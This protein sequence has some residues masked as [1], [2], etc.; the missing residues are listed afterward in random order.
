MVCSSREPEFKKMDSQGAQ[1]SR[2]PVEDG[3]VYT[4]RWGTVSP[5]TVLAAVAAALEPQEVEISLLLTKPDQ[6]NDT[7]KME[8]FDRYKTMPLSVQVHN[9]W[10]AT[11]AGKVAVDSLLAG[12]VTATRYGMDGPGIESRR[13][14][15]FPHRSWS[16][17]SLLNNG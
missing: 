1:L 15:N 3:V 5:G 14:R 6:A 9:T 12:P 17:P 7:D 13:G 2:C 10:A 4:S 16:P 11:L 8:K